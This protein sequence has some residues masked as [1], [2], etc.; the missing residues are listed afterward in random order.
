MKIKITEDQAKRLKLI[1]EN[2]NPLS[3]FELFC[4]SK[5]Q[6][7]NKLYVNVTN[8]S[9]AEIINNDI[10]MASISGTLDKIES[11][12]H[13]SNN[14]AY[15]YINTLPESDLDVR[16]DRAYDSVKDKLNSLQIIV[17]DLERL[18]LSSLDHSLT[19]SFEDTKPKDITNIQ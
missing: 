5:I 6:E 7:I 4:K 12:L 19:A 3:Q 10:E 18:Q 15:Q 9:V 16:I 8:L 1:S 14:R 17:M 11:D 2:A 13:V